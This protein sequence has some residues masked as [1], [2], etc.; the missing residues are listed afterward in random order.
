M[1][2]LQGWSVGRGMSLITCCLGLYGV[3]MHTAVSNCDDGAGAAT[4]DAAI[5]AQSHQLAS[6]PPEPGCLAAP[7][8]LAVDSDG[9]VL[10]R[11]SLT[12]NGGMCGCCGNG[13][14]TYTSSAADR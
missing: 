14:P 2:P 1:K 11:R 13:R 8:L 6:R 3:V 7:H 5:S 9:L 10:G 4:L 12:D